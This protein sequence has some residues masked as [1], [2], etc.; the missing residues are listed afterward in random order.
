MQYNTS[1][2][3]AITAA[4]WEAMAAAGE[5]HLRRAA[6][7]APATGFTNYEARKPPVNSQNLPLLLK[8]NFKR[9]VTPLQPPRT[10][11][12]HPLRKSPKYGYFQTFDFSPQTSR[13]DTPLQTRKSKAIA[14]EFL[15]DLPSLLFATP[16]TPLAAPIPETAK[17]GRFPK[18]PILF[19]KPAMRHNGARRAAHRRR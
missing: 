8:Q 15:T 3:T 5:R 9:L 17:H 13:C 11:L 16:R 7:S 1:H 6:P 2:E 14:K 10:S 19:P 18:S 4:Q 12:A